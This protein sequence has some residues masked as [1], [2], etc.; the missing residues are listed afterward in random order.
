MTYDWS[1]AKLVKH[2]EVLAVS[3]AESWGSGQP[4]CMVYSVHGVTHWYVMLLSEA[5]VGL[6]VHWYAV[7]VQVSLVPSTAP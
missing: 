7:V 2:I 5:T 4:L 6:T 1:N 3:G